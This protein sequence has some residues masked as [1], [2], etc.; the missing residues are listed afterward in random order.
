MT[1]GPGPS[2]NASDGPPSLP[3]GPGP[4]TFHTTSQRHASVTQGTKTLVGRCFQPTLPQPAKWL[5]RLHQLVCLPNG[6]LAANPLPRSS[7][8]FGSRWPLST[9][10]VAHEVTTDVFRKSIDVEHR[11][12]QV[13]WKMDVVRITMS[14]EAANQVIQDTLAFLEPEDQWAIIAPIAEELERRGIFRPQ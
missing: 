14:R 11:G 1:P 7:R 6:K 8:G 5:D 4:L 10:R 13:K 3:Q 9:Q 12:D 2:A